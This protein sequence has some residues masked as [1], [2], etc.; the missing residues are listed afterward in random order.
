MNILD[1]NWPCQTTRSHYL[2]AFF[3]DLLEIG[4]VTANTDWY[5][6]A[7]VV[8]LCLTSTSKMMTRLTLCGVPVRREG[9]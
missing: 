7:L 3:D 4:S 6:V 8:G 2:T 9:R 1:L 5:G